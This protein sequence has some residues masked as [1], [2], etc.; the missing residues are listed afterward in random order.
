MTGHFTRHD[1]ANDAN[2]KNHNRVMTQETLSPSDSIPK[3]Y[4]IFSLKNECHVTCLNICYS[5]LKNR[6]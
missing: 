2:K 6:D 4:K 3:P 1:T 5:F